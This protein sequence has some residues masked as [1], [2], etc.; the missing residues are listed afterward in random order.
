MNPLQPQ[1]DPLQNDPPNRSKRTC[2]SHHRKMNTKQRR[3]GCKAKRTNT[4][5]TRRKEGDIAAVGGFLFYE[6]PILEDNFLP[7]TRSAFLLPSH[8]RS[9]F[10]RYLSHYFPLNFFLFLWETKYAIATLQQSQPF[11]SHSSFAHSVLDQILSIHRF[12]EFVCVGGC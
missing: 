8:S 6:H 5:S 2:K 9:I 1:N 4:G 7:A 10:P 12:I 11:N 3:N